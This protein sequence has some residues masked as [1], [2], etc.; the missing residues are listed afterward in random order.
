MVD[1]RETLVTPVR[2]QADVIVCGGGM[3]GIAAA[4][5]AARHGADVLLIEK[6]IVFGGLATAGLI[7]W[8]EP[9]CDG[10]GNKIM[11]GLADELLHLAIRYGPDTLNEKW[12]SDPAHAECGKRYS[13]FFSPAVFSMALDGFLR[14]AGV[15]LLLDSVVVKPVMEGGRCDGVIVENK[16]GRGFYGAKAVVD[17]TGDADVLSRAGVPC[18]TGQNYLTYIGYVTDTACCRDA[19]K[20]GE[21]LRARKWFNAGSDLWGKGHPEN[22][23]RLSGVTAEEV[24][25]YVLDGRKLFFD[26]LC[27]RP[28]EERDVSGMPHM[29][30]LRTTRR[31]MGAYE[32]IETDMGKRFEDSVGVAGDFTNRGRVYELPFRMLYHEAFDNLFTAGR[33][34]SSSGWAWEVTRVIPVAAATGQAAGTAAAICARNGLSA[35]ALCGDVQ[36]LLR[37][38]GVRL[39][40][41]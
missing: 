14:E 26:K 13:T 21:L 18:R 30:Q 38:D 11:Y 2:G 15:R 19:A 17:T 9:L 4:V 25:R 32:L 5:S 8:Y 37:E 1:I 3:G 16:T 27:E 34:V 29:A 23:A 33:T 28:R 36:S 41:E 6:S 31:L 7:S 10:V 39:H 12:R 40:M 24:T 20:S 35:K 22:A